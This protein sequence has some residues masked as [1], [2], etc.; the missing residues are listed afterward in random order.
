MDKKEI[1]QEA[2]NFINALKSATC[3]AGGSAG[4]VDKMTIR[5]LYELLLPNGIK[6][7]FTLKDFDNRKYY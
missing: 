1:K 2:N 7:H 5:E 3:L 6:L 4:I